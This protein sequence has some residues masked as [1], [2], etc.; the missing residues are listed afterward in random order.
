MNGTRKM[1]EITVTTSAS[2]IGRGDDLVKRE[3]VLVGLKNVTG[4]TINEIR[5]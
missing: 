4:L 3:T 5:A 1:T 2:T